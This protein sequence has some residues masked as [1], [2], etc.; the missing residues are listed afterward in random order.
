MN[1]EEILAIEEQLAQPIKLRSDDARFAEQARKW[2]RSLIDD[3]KHLRD[4]NREL[5]A[6]ARMLDAWLREIAA[7]VAP[8]KHWVTPPEIKQAVHDVTLELE[9]ERA[10][11]ERQSS[12]TAI[13]TRAEQLEIT[14]QEIQGLRDL[15][16]RLVACLHP[17]DRQVLQPPSTAMAE[18]V[19]E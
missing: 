7:L 2:L 12:L 15:L 4:E 18:V 6:S 5:H 3:V 8:G 9:R 14:A 17:A 11:S 19:E 1:D 13:R 10:R 16:Q